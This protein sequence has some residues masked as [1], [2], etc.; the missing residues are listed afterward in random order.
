VL[1]DLA[2]P[3]LAIVPLKGD[4]LAQER[5]AKLRR[6]VVALSMLKPACS[7]GRRVSFSVDATSG[8]AMGCIS[9]LRP[10]PLLFSGSILSS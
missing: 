4:M 1:N 2:D 7:N 9:P 10:P 3:P 5:L 6:I 8:L